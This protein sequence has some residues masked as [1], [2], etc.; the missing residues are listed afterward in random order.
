MSRLNI[1]L[2]NFFYQLKVCNVAHRMT[3]NLGSYTHL[4]I[5]GDFLSNRKA[6]RAERFTPKTTA[7]GLDG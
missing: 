2:F 7:A 4:P 3:A 6:A 5:A 1:C